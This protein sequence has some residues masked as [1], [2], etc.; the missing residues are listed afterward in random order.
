MSNSGNGHTNPRD[1]SVKVRKTMV[2]RIYGKGKCH[3]TTRHSLNRK[4]LL[5][6]PSDTYNTRI[7]CP[8][9]CIDLL[10]E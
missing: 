6:V 3:V 8:G 1:T 4:R 9:T 5:S 2:K 10:S 7:R